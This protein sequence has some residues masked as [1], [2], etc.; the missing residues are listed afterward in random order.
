MTAF[1]IVRSKTMKRTLVQTTLLA[2]AFSLSAC[3]T[4]QRTA[5]VSDE[6]V[7]T[8]ATSTAYARY[9]IVVAAS[10]DEMGLVV[11]SH[12]FALSEDEKDR[13]AWF[14]ETYKHVG[15][16]DIW[17]TAPVGSQNA[18]AS[19]GAA[20]EVASVMMDRGIDPY[21]IK[22][23]SYEADAGDDAAPM[24]ISFKRY[25]AYAKE[26][27]NFSASIMTAPGNEVSRNFG[28]ASQSNLAA[29]IEDPRD[30]EAVPELDPTDA[31]RRAEVF[32]K[33]R[34]GQATAS[35]RTE[36]ESG[37]TSRVGQ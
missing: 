29:L 32:D 10:K 3:G 1:D 2:A 28:C 14:A 25:H 6:A 30:L 33:Y 18:A 11:P 34:A 9:P 13:V 22:M 8:V 27:G 26:C 21:R 12:V 36:A 16:G 24:T 4:M 23:T 5:S 19:I 17:V 37:R 35:E 20:A 7:A 15:H 31:A